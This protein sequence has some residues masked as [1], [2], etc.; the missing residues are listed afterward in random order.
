MA[1]TQ[2]QIAERLGVSKTLVSRVLSGKAHLVGITEST[3]KRVQMASEEMGYVPN[4]AAL[5]LKGIASRTIGVVVYDFKDAFF[6]AMIEGLQAQAHEHNFSLIL[7]GFK[8]RVPQRS[9]LAPLHKHSID[10][11]IILGSDTRAE[12]CRAFEKMPI[13]R[14]GHGNAQE[15]SVRIAIDEEDAA[16]QLFQHLARL[17]YP[18][19]IFLRKDLPAHQLREKALKQAATRIGCKFRS[20]VSTQQAFEAGLNEMQAILATDSAEVIL[21]AT[22]KIAMGALHAMH[23]AARWLPVIGFDDIPAADQFFPSITTMRQPYHEMSKLAFQAII[24]RRP[25]TDIL[26]AGKLIA[27]RSG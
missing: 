13:V 3:I 7:A 25:P 23:D 18:D 12:W 15:N 10:G 11:L 4:A 24:D 26:L 9:D 21:C 2:K 19:L 1:V 14:I 6:G 22:D 5:A 17:S 27:R 8:Q 16:N 20:I